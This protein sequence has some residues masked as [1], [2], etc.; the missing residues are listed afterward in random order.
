MTLAWQVVPAAKARSTCYIF[1]KLE[2]QSLKRTLR[3]TPEVVIG[4][5]K[6]AAAMDFAGCLRVLS[7]TFRTSRCFCHKCDA[8][9]EK[10]GAV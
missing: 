4:W 2:Q 9:P 1:Q 8:A 5:N 3:N 6:G 10:L 7:F